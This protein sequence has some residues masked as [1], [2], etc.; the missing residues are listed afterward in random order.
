VQATLNREDLRG[1]DPGESIER[2]PVAATADRAAARLAEAARERATA[3][4]VFRGAAQQ[5][6]AV[7]AAFTARDAAVSSNRTAID[8]GRWASGSNDLSM[9]LATFVLVHRFESVIDAANHHLMR[10]SNGRLVLQSFDEAVGRARRGGL[11]IRVMDLHTE[12]ARSP[13]T[14]SGGETFYTSLSLAL[15]LA[16]IVTTES[17]GVELDTL[18]VDEG[19]GSLDPDTLETVMA[20]LDGLQSDGR[21]LGLVSHVTEM[22]DRIPERIEVRRTR[23]TGPSGLNVVA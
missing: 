1:V 4:A 17:G 16:E 21:I 15:G 13:K 14:L 6:D 2:D 20:V 22:K 12:T 8:L 3:D 11:G 10:M 23:P 5:G 7:R 19:F 18:F 9:D